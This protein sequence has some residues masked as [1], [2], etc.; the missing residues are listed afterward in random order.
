MSA[1][2]VSI[3]LAWAGQ[4]RNVQEHYD[5]LMC[6]GANG[7]F[8]NIVATDGAAH[9]TNDC[10]HQEQLLSKGGRRGTRKMC[11]VTVAKTIGTIEIASNMWFTA[12]LS[13]NI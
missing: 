6:K 2:F 5:R 4:I 11:E 1:A 3:D 7:G 8:L 13:Q 9:G 10:R 12:L